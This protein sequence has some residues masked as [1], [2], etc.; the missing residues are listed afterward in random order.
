[1]WSLKVFAPK[2]LQF[3][4]PCQVP[5]PVNLAGFFSF[6]EVFTF[7]IDGLAFAC[8]SGAQPVWRYVFTVCFFPVG[9]LWLAFCGAVSRCIPRLQSWDPATRQR[10]QVGFTMT[11]GSKVV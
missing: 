10:S 8:I 11:G 6:M 2:K 4:P 3:L 1:M 9:I 7:D 5:W